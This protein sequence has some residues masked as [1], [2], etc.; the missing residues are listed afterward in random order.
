MGKQYDEGKHDE[1]RWAQRK[2]EMKIQKR[3]QDLFRR[4]CKTGFAVMII[5][6]LA[7]VIWNK[8]IRKVLLN[9]GAS[10]NDYF[11]AEGSGAEPGLEK[12]TEPSSSG[13]GNP[14]NSAA[15][16]WN[17][18]NGNS[19]N[20]AAQDGNPKNTAAKD[21]DTGNTAAQDG[22][23]KDPAAQDEN[24]D[25]TAG[26]HE[27][28]A[29]NGDEAGNEAGSKTSDAEDADG[30]VSYKTVKNTRK[31]KK[32]I[33]SSYAVLIDPD[34][35]TILAGK[36]ETSRIV[37]ASMTKV[38]TLLTAVEHIDDP[39]D[40][41]KI[42]IEITD[43]C[44][45]NGC[46]IAGFE[47][48]E[49]VTVRDLMYG[50]ILPSGADAALGL[51]EYVAGSQKAFMKMMNEKLDELGLSKTAHFTNCVGIYDEDHYCTVLDMAVIMNA[52]MENEVCREVLS[53]HT[54]T[55]SKTKQHPEGIA[56]SNWFLRRI[57]DKDTGG[58]VV[59]G[60]T[61]YVTQS[62]NCAVSYGTDKKGRNYICV[63]AN[64]PGTWKCI[65][66]HVYLYKRF[67]KRKLPGS[68]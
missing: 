34:N 46:S 38:L 43:Y 54:Y 15:Q 13:D 12:D 30:N 14:E 61:G 62:G 55:T 32:Q 16:D 36:N 33:D 28:D 2:Q 44:Y 57:E 37:P 25:H 35:R 64:A 66:D 22:N 6:V 59:C 5:A 9:K 45:Q 21:K 27:D 11:T 39:D 40:K 8:G 3:R 20:T 18:E 51:A 26:D 56:L 60:K 29:G 31:L 41:F 17:P 1:T 65:Y 52:A 24:P 58:E 50:T 7:A 23:Q 49:K 10:E 42:T 47:N 48:G 4:I 63:T 19:E 68:F 67:S 53:A